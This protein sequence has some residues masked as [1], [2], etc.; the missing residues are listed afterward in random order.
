MNNLAKISTFEAISLVLIVMLNNIILNLPSDIV[1]NT[2]SSAWLTVIIMITLVTSFTI[3]ICKLFKNFPCMDIVD[4][5][6]FLGGKYLKFIIGISFII[7]FALVSANFLRMFSDL[8]QIIFLKHTPLLFII[9]FFL[10]GAIL[11]NKLGIASIA[12]VSSISVIISLISFVVLMLSLSDHYNIY[13]LFPIFGYGPIQTFLGA[14]TNLYGFSGIVLLYFI[15]PILTSDKHFSKVAIISIIIS[16]ILLLFSIL[17]Q[18]LIFGSLFDSEVLAGL[19]LSSRIL[20]FGNFFERVDAIFTFIWIFSQISYLSIACSLILYILRKIAN[21][22]EQNG[23]LYALIMVIFGICV[24]PKNYP[25]ITD[26]IL[27]FA[28][29]TIII[30]VFIITPIILILANLKFKG[31]YLKNKGD[32]HG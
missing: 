7:L 18:L 6:E 1:K 20:N 27:P 15:K 2:T 3:V 5:S 14:L 13:N 31:K 9:S 32:T 25:E 26:F 19:V 22:S 8:L 12:K 17:N 24:F 21:T 23:M 28:N 10:L 30:L 11:S 4:I 16:G 29:N